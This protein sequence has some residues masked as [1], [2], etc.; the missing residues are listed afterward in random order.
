MKRDVTCE[1]KLILVMY[2]SFLYV[3][4]NKYSYGKHILSLQVQ[5]QNKEMKTD[6]TKH[7]KLLK[8]TQEEKHRLEVENQQVGQIWRSFNQQ[9]GQIWKSR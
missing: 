6:L 9:V 1:Q 3:S 7:K 8:D 4:G 2:S 5:D